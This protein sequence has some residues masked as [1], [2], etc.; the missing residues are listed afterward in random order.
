LI[1]Q[2]NSVVHRSGVQGFPDTIAF[3]SSQTL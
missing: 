2:G 1:L 3:K